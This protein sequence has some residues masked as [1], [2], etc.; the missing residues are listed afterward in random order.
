MFKRLAKIAFFSLAALALAAS[1]YGAEDKIKQK[2]EADEF[3]RQGEAEYKREDYEAAIEKF[4]RC[5]AKDPENVVAQFNIGVCYSDLGEPDKAIQ[6]YRKA[7][8]IEPEYYDAYFNL[9]RIY[10]RRGDYVEAVAN[11][12]K[13]LEG[14]PYAPDVLYNCAYAMTESG[15]VVEAIDAWDRYL[16]IAESMPEEA[17]W[18][19]RAKEYLATLENIGAGGSDSAK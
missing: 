2:K 13:A 11:Y 19:E 5:L 10:H 1:A 4:E 3:F 6:A 12:R 18:V 15:Q 17:K 7:L 16:T 8:A 9:G 14:D